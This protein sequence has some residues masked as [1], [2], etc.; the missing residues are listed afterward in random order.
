VYRFLIPTIVLSLLSGFCT[1]SVIDAYL[2]HP[3]PV[4][5]VIADDS[6]SP[7]PVVRID[8]IRNG[9]LVGSVTGDVRL[10]ARGRSILPDGSG[11]FVITDRS[12]LT[13]EIRI[14]VPAG[15]RFVASKRGKKY[16]P[17]DSASAAGLSPSNR[18]YFTN[19]A[20]AERAGYAE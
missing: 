9:V 4:P 11:S 19:A 5:R 3:A 10:A 8:G 20:A 14:M 18:L 6:P 17:V 13:N 7:V 2:F 15:M 16:Y 1:G 12:V